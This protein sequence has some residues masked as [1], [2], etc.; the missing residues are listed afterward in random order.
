M[1]GKSPD[2][3][4][5][6]QVRIIRFAQEKPVDRSA[7][8]VAER[9]LEKPTVV[10]IY[11][12]GPDP[13]FDVKAYSEYLQATLGENFTIVVEGNPFLQAIAAHPEKKDELLTA[14]G[15]AKQWACIGH[16]FSSFTDKLS[17]DQK[18]VLEEESLEQLANHKPFRKSA[19][20]QRIKDSNSLNKRGVPIQ[21]NEYYSISALQIAY[22]RALNED[23][24]NSDTRREIAVVITGRGLGEPMANNRIHMRAGSTLGNIAI[25]S[26][27]GI[28]EAPAKPAE[29]QREIEA[30][31]STGS[32]YGPTSDQRRFKIFRDAL[33]AGKYDYQALTI[34]FADC[35]LDHADPRITDAMKGISLQMIL[36]ACDEY[37]QGVAKC[38]TSNLNTQEPDLTIH[39]RMHD[40]HKAE[41]VIRTQVDKQGN[42]EFCEFHT[43]IFTLLQGFRKKK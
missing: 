12:D 1:D 10:H 34:A 21:D 41:E 5:V 11:Q 40:A 31:Y 37:W 18:K 38:S 39:C 29:V 4:P 14:L 28:V 17:T 9:L 25:I 30:S 27:T 22:G 32:I 13:A 15:E 42:P 6:P 43:K 24:I 16:G 19:L 3:S 7:E 20:D 23:L 33:H 36:V 2:N 8:A 26:T 35:M